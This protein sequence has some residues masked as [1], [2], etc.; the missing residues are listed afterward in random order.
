M[1]KE[2]E[3]KLKKMIKRKEELKE[4]AKEEKDLLKA[5]E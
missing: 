4:I 1:A 5:L 3:K 2:S